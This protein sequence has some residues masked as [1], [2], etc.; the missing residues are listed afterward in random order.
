MFRPSVFLCLLLLIAINGAAIAQDDDEL[1]PSVPEGD[2]PWVVKI[3]FEDKETVQSLVNDIDVWE[4]HP[5]RGYLEAALSPGEYRKLVSQG[6]RLEYDS[7]QTG[8]LAR[9]GIPLKMQFTGIPGFP[10]YR[11]VEETFA[12]AQQWA[13]D[14]PDLVSWIDVGDSWEKTQNPQAGWDLMVLKLTQSAIPGP[15]P[16]FFANCSIHAREYT[17][18]P[19]CM[20]FAELLVEGYGVDA[21]VTWILDHHEVHLMPIT[22]PDGRKQAE[23]GL[24]WRKNTNNDYCSNSNSRGADLN[25]NFDFQWG[26][27]GG[28]S[29]S[30]CSTTFRGAAPASEP[31]LQ[32]LQA[33]VQSIFPDQRV[34]DLVTPSPA[35]ATG[36]AIDIH[37]SGELVLWS[38]G[39]TADPAPNGTALQTFGRKLAFYNG[40]TPQK[41]IELYVTDG[42]SKDYYYGTL[43]VAGLVYEL[44]TQFFESCSYFENSILPGNLP[45]LVYAA[46]VARTPFLTPAGPEATA[47]TF[48][49]GPFAAGEMALLTATV[50]DTRFNNTN[51]TEPT[52]TIASAEAFLD[53][54]PWDAGAVP[55]AMVASDGTFNQGAEGVEVAIDTTGLAPGRHIVFIHGTDSAGNTGPVSAVFLDLID[56]ASAPVVQGVVRSAGTLAPLSATVTIGPFTTSTDPGTGAYS[57]QVPPGTYDITAEAADHLSSTANGV[58]ASEFAT[59]QQNFDL[60]AL[61]DCTIV[62]FDDGSAA[63]WSNSGASTC[64]TGSFVVATPTQQV[65][66]GVTTQVGGDHTSGSGNAYFSATNTAA[67]TN[68]VDGGTCI[69]TS[70]VYAIS[71]ESTLSIWYFHGQ[72]DAG[73]DAGDFFSLEMSTDGGSSWSTLASFGDETVNAA[74]TE[75]TASVPGGSNVQFR[76]QV[77]DAPGGGDLVEAGVDDLF[78]CPTAPACSVD[79]DC[80]D[81]LYC[82]GTESCNAGSCQAGT[83]IVCDDGVACTDDVCNEATDA[84]DST[85][86]DANCDDGTFC[87]G[88]EVCDAV[89][90]CQPATGPDCDD[91]VACTEDSC[92]EATDSCDNAPNDGL[93]DNGTFCDGAETC[94][95]VNDCQVGTPVDCDD[96]VSCT[97]D[98]CNEATD[99]CDHAADDGLCDNGAFCDGAETC[100]PFND[101]QPGSDPCPGE[102]CDEAGDVCVACIDDSD[103]DD[104]IFCNG[105]ETCNAG[106]CQAGTPVV[107]DD[108]VGCTDDACNEATDGCDH[109]PDDGLC[110]NGAFCDGAETCDA[111]ND[112]QPGT[113]PCTGSQTC[114]EVADLCVGGGCLHEVDFESGDGGWSQGA[115][116]CTTGS[117]IVG[118]PDATAWQIGGGNPGQAFFT[119]NNAGGIGTD[120]V[121]GGTCEALSP[122]LDASGEAAVEVTLD[123]YHGQRDNGDD[124]ND[125]FTVEVLSDGVVVDTMVSIGDVTNAASWSTLSTVVTNPGDLQLR[126]RATDAAGAGDIVEAGI[127]NVSVCPTTPPPPCTLEEDFESGAGGWTNDGSSTCSTGTF[128]V[129]TPTAQSNGGVVTQV[130]GDHTSGSGNAFFS[131]TNTSAGSNDIDGGTCIVTSPV[132][133][134]SETSEV[135]VWFFHGQRDAGDDGGDFFSLEISTDGGGTWS[136]MASFGD[137]TVSAAW[138]E[139][140]AS[141]PAGAN[142]QLRVQAADGPAGGDLVEAG[143]DDISICPVAP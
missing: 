87:N 37:S 79:A 17:T 86:N 63:G 40:H 23:T 22:N 93:C 106:V 54:P 135:S 24:S 43:G 134:V 52:Q 69:V 107:C 46:K 77:A 1:A 21:D 16:V 33:Y 66:G 31:E 136:T 102:A 118:T 140:T 96:G 108:G 141:V 51:G 10:C 105:A 19:L 30:Q 103:C 89:L 94:D 85:A 62:D 44:G 18:A 29:G 137:V 131:A 99:N 65:N 41:G 26:C 71:D 82:N 42:T 74:W 12:Q 127:D 15:K 70:P 72:R 28:S 78:I 36:V 88:A 64:S 7:V 8:H 124:A 53:L 84:C 61:A 130:G 95:P 125:G 49:A 112:C 75:A 76:V 73:D 109:T 123:Y 3:F 14:H 91:G 34:D 104:G 2:G 35:D 114:D 6:L 115:D 11:T 129:G 5:E 9:L 13:T 101:C 80:D 20:N 98:S 111:V 92:N 25:R 100:D 56:P 81:G 138:A 142:V 122:V 39:F 45:S 83:A 120:D 128:V 90:D 4:V 55:L 97:V 60:I 132:Y 58:V 139:I 47:L 68:D 113:A 67:G 119:Q 48:A 143:V 38:W 50:D 32:A 121:D 110:D 59:V 57:L 27:C 116:T 126:V 117:F 133:A